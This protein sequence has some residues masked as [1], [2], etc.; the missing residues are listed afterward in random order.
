MTATL[1]KLDSRPGLEAQA[2]PDSQ[3][4]ANEEIAPDVL[5]VDPSDPA[6]EFLNSTGVLPKLIALRTLNTEFRK[7]H[8]SFD[9]V[10]KAIEADPDLL[11]RFLKFANGGWFSSRVQVDSPYMA[12]TRFG[13]QGFYKLALAA[14]LSQGIGELGTKFKIWP[15]LEAVA[16]VGESIARELAPKSIEDVF[17]AGLLH[18]AAVAPMERQLPDY[19]YF[20]EC[21]MNMDPLV[22][23]LEKNCHGFDHAEAG[24]CL[25]GALAFGDHIVE[26]V[27]HHHDE[28]LAALSTNESK[29]VLSLLLLTKK[30]HWMLRTEK[31]K[32]FETSAEKSLL[33][34]FS[35]ALNVS[36]GRIQNVLSD[37]V[38]ALKARP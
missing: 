10:F 11:K 15:H 33:S 2:P 16:R 17:S 9:E 12:F 38:E 19:L 6:L 3:A 23:T 22:T 25:A 7:D 37:T 28:S 35:L 4:I 29:V 13:T 30:A 32:G 27:A 20:L 24:K 36:S 26:A 21:A 8:P 1:T 14:L 5:P 18:D 31:K 34:E